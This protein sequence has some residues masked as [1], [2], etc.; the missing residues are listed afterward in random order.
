MPESWMAAM[1]Q[2]LGL[3][4]LPRAPLMGYMTRSASLLYAMHGA[5]IVFV[6][7]DIPRYRPLIR[8]LAWAAVAHGL[9]LALI[10]LFE[11]MPLWWTVL[12]GPVYFLLGAAVLRLLRKSQAF[13]EPDAA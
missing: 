9:L 11:Q 5:M 2:G 3:G 4:E 7:Y 13:A 8:F 10:D 1:H 12:E 6:S